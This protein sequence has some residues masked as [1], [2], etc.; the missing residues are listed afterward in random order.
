MKET[1]GR[2]WKATNY[3]TKADDNYKHE[4]KPMTE[5]E[6]EDFNRRADWKEATKIIRSK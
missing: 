4:W 5:E 2:D 1:K 6:K 3:G